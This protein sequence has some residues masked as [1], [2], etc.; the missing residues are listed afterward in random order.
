MKYKIQLLKICTFLRIG[1]VYYRS[2]RTSYYTVSFFTFKIIFRIC[3]VIQYELF[4]YYL[5]FSRGQQPRQA[6]SVPAPVARDWSGPHDHCYM[7]VQGQGRTTH[8][9]G[10]GRGRVE[11]DGVHDS[12]QD[13]GGSE[14]RGNR[15]GEGDQED[16]EYTLPLVGRVS[17]QVRLFEERV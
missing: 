12:S 8:E 3:F 2:K 6:R 15:R 5:V 10:V 16:H 7:S 9:H 11:M 14:A 17:G 4:L 1:Q 13:V